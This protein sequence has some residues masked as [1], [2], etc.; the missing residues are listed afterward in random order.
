MRRA[1]SPGQL[2]VPPPWPWPRPSPRARPSGRRR[3]IKRPPRWGPVHPGDPGPG[4]AGVCLP[5]LDLL[6]APSREGNQAAK[7][8][9]D[10]TLSRLAETLK[11]FGINGRVIGAVQGP[12]VTRY[13]VHA[14]SRA[15]SS[16]RSPTCPTISHWRLGASGVRDGA[17][18]A[19]RSPW[20][21]SR[22]PTA[23]SPLCASVTSS[24]PGSSPGT[25]PP[26][27]SAVGKDIGGNNIVGDIA[28]LPHV[29][30]AG[31]TGSG[32]SVCTNSL[33]RQHPL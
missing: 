16:A 22:C 18:T 5:L 11:S 25:R 3:S 14:W 2:W 4:G 33:H 12:S 17:G 28:K 7:E 20:W 31:T 9:L 8:E 6:A 29:L 23:P 21:A 13:D 19:T 10:D 27:P 32:K 24:N 26:W 15:S 1:R 30:I